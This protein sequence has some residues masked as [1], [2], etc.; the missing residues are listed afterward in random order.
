MSR[1][2]ILCV[3]FL[4]IL[5]P[6]AFSYDGVEVGMSKVDITP[7]VGVPLGGY[8]GVDRRIIPWDI[9]NKHKYAK[10]LRPS[11]GII[12]PIYSK[13]M[14]VKKD[15]KS[16][17]LISQDLIGTTL[18]FRKD[19]IDR[20]RE[21]NLQYDAVT[22]VATHTHSG[23]GTLSRKKF[24]SILAMD[25]F[26]P[27]IYQQVINKVVRGVIEAE[28]RLTP[29]QLYSGT[30]PIE[31]IQRNRRDGNAYLN[32][33][34]SYLVA[35]DFT[36]K[37][38]GGFIH[39]AVHP[40][41]YGEKNLKF[42]GDI[43]G[44]IGTDIESIIKNKNKR[45]PLVDSNYEPVMLYING[46]EG[47][48]SLVRNGQKIE[49]I[50]K[51]FIDQTQFGKNFKNLKEVESVFS[52]KDGL[53]RFEKKPRILLK[54]CL[55]GRFWKAIPRILNPTFKR[56]FGRTGY[57]QNFSIGD[58][59][60]VAWPGE[61]TSEVGR[62]VRE[63]FPNPDKTLVFGLANDH[64]GYFTTPSEYTG[65]SYEACLSLFGENN[66]MEIIDFIKNEFL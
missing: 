22:I 3:S 56:N 27:K 11:D 19:I 12:D 1:I 37:W 9:F 62:R 59:N 42:S 17:L 33:N 57:I 66:A 50:S 32:K 8:G 49:E 53:T 15:G 43:T 13:V 51:R 40:I 38:L 28:V 14:I 2:I 58:F 39:F 48:V 10:Y 16:T 7:P 60:I 52:F 20:L 25:K 5:A 4:F 61:P 44:R 41:F 24:W 63:L 46:A 45:Y 35:K 30:D 54:N 21:I 47:D 6:S 18:D 64:L 26:Q 31:G 36:G 29:A 34:A 65:G 23:P 55:K